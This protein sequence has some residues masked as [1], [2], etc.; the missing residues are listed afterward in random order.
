[1]LFAEL[2]NRFNHLP[3]LVDFDWVERL[4]ASGII[5]LFNC[6]VKSPIDG[7]NAA[8]KD[9]HEAN[10]NRRLNLALDQVIDQCPQID[11]IFRI[12]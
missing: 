5:V 3:L 11:G 1:M 4:V 6:T 10:Q 8:L 7:V 12:R 2:G 9:I